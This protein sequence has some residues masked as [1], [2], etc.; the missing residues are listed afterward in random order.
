M[1]ATDQY[2]SMVLFISLILVSIFF[3]DLSVERVFVVGKCENV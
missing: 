1:K 2:F 3:F